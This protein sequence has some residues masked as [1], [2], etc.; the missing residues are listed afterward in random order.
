M[1]PAR[2]TRVRRVPARGRY[3]RAAVD[4]V[5]DSGLVAH[6]A[7]ADGGLPYCIPMLYARVEDRVLVHGSSASRLMRTLASGADAC[8]TVTLVHGLVLARSAFEHS[9]S[10]ESVMLFGRFATVDAEAAREQA[11]RSFTDALVP[12]RWEEVRKPDRKELKAT[13]ILSLEIAEASVKLRSGPPDDDGSDDALLDVWAGEIPFMTG[14]AAPVPSPG[15]REG[16]P[17]AP[18]VDALLQDRRP[19]ADP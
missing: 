19:V 14:Y 6:V 15:L 8:L 12:G 2:A 18:S 17:L 1:T 16:I 5:L 11:F 7:F 4:A 10:Y 13:V 3:D 9:A